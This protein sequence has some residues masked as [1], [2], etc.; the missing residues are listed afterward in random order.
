MYRK[1]FCSKDVDYIEAKALSSQLNLTK[2]ALRPDK[3]M[4]SGLVQFTILLDMYFNYLERRMEKK[5]KATVKTKTA[6]KKV[7]DLKK[8]AATKVAKKVVKKVV[9]KPAA[10]K[11]AK[12]AKK[13]VAMPKSTIK[14]MGLK[15]PENFS[16]SA[17]KAK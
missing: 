6:V 16:K 1:I 12:T 13:V 11:V 2:M 4:Y 8:K 7:K 17:K 14:K 10:K 9:K 5:I 15:L 3:P